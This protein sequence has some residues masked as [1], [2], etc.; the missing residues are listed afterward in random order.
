MSGKRWANL[1]P[2]AAEQGAALHAYAQG[3]GRCWMSH[4]HL[5][6]MDAAAEYV[7]Q[8]LRSTHGPGWLASLRL[9]QPPS[10]LV[11][12]KHNTAAI[13]VQNDELGTIGQSLSNGR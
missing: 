1:P 3:H 11:Q 13:V 4:L 2:P 5:D 7:L 6:W 9:S 10:K 8:A 12:L